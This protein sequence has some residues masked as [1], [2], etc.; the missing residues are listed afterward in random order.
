M[1]AQ[2]TT[3]RPV[4]PRRG[5]GKLLAYALLSVGALVVLYPF[6][7]M[8]MNSVK[9]G[10]EILH[11]P[12]A[13]PSQIT[14]SGYAGVFARLNVLR[15]FRNSLILAISITL[16]NTLL[17]AMAAYA[18]AKIPFPGRGPIFSFMLATMMIPSV[19]LLIPTYVIMYNLGWVNTF[20]ALIVPSAISVYNIFLLHQF[21]RGIPDELIEAARLDGASDL[22]VFWRI[23]MPL[24]RPALV[25][26]AI[27]TFMGSWNDFFGPLLY[28]NRPELWTVQ[29]GLLQFQA[30]VPGENAQEIWAAVT[31]ISLPPVILFFFLQDQ[32][33]QAFA[34]AKF[35]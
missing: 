11:S 3:S 24:V 1:A 13:L 22:G 10:P 35:K 29:L 26:V 34:N 31:M 30:G 33:I 32:F 4:L 16:L 28:L 21:M 15:L 25:T 20:Q 7:Y 17:S 27:L 12:N 5:R 8:V 2:A 19:L 6:F 18:I 14:F 9:P 23:I